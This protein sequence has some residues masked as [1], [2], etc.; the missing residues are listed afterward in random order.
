[1]KILRPRKREGSKARSRMPSRI[2]FDMIPN[3]NSVKIAY[4]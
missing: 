4:F 1:M 2:S 3:A